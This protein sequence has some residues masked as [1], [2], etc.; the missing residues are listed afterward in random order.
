MGH[1]IR[2]AVAKLL[3]WQAKEQS[4]VHDGKY[5]ADMFTVQRIL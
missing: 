5:W 4:G 1:N 2:D 3:L